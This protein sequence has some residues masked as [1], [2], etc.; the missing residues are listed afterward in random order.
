MRNILRE[1]KASRYLWKVLGQRAVNKKIFSKKVGESAWRS[2][3]AAL[4]P[5]YTDK[6]ITD[7]CLTGSKTEELGAL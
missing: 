7:W 5:S 6:A 4:R 3:S 1:G 2:D